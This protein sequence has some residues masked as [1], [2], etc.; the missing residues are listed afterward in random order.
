MNAQYNFFAGIIG[1]IETK[2]RNKSF[3]VLFFLGKKNPPRQVM[4]GGF[5][6]FRQKE[7]R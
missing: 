5:L 4:P 6:N 1:I 7:A 3:D 2:A